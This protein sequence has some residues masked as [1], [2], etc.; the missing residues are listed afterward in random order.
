LTEF[1]P[2]W[3][4]ALWIAELWGKLGAAATL[5]AIYGLIAATAM[6]H[7]LTVVTRN[8]GDMA[9]TGVALLIPFATRI[10]Q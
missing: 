7:G 6:V 3:A 4:G 5:P 9:R 10:S 1:G 2:V 8:F